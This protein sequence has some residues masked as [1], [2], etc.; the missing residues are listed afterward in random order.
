V[1]RYSAMRVWRC[2]T[3]IRKPTGEASPRGYK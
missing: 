3:A 1:T 2:T